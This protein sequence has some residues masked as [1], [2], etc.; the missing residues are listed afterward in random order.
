M[1]KSNCVLTGV[2]ASVGVFTSAGFFVTLAPSMMS[3]LLGYPFT[4]FLIS[5]VT[6][7]DGSLVA[8]KTEILG[9]NIPFGFVNSFYRKRRWAR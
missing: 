9:T 8:K 5:K 1:S 7:S 3:L 2:F 6:G 4:V